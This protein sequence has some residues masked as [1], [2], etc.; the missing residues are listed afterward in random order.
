MRTPLKIVGLSILLALA[1]AGCGTGTNDNDAIR[2]AINAHLSG[3]SN[4]N[5]SAFDTEVQKVDIQ[6]D[7]AKV[8]VAFHVKGGPGVMQLT[9]DLKKTGGT[10]AVVELNPVGSNFTHPVPGEGGATAPGAATVP[11]QDIMDSFH[12]RLAT[13]TK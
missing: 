9:Y 8:D 1:G 13:P 10:W 12:E 11:P 3:N 6:G 5:M 4:L 7:Q 2:T